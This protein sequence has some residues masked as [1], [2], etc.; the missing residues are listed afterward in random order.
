M[1]SDGI[2]DA[3]LRRHAGRDSRRPHALPRR[4]AAGDRAN[5][6]GD[7]GSCGDRWNGRDRRVLGD[8]HRRDRGRAGLQPVRFGGCGGADRLRVGLL[9]HP[10][11]SARNRDGRASGHRRCR[12][13]RCAG[14]DADKRGDRR[15]RG[16]RHPQHQLPGE[17]P[18]AGRSGRGRPSVLCG[19]D[20]GLPGRARR[21]HRHLWPGVGR[22]RPLLQHVPAPDRR[23]LVVG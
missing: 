1:E 6:V 12:Y 23:A 9:Q 7:R 3:V 19:T 5:G 13:H 22:V 11:D 4:A 2:A 18:G 17:H 14:G 15:A 20:D 8:D 21:H 16:D 10:R